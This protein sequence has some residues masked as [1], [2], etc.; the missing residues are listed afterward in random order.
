MGALGGHWCS[1]QYV[2]VIKVLLVCRNATT[3][4]SWSQ[5][6]IDPMHTKIKGEFFGAKSETEWKALTEA[7]LSAILR[8][9]SK[10]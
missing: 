9:F 5:K 1:V 6:E 4:S 7:V 2:A 3:S 8:E 10:G